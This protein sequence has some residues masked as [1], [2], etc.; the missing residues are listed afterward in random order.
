[1]VEIVKSAIFAKWLSGL[2]DKKAQRRI[3]KRLEHIENGNFGDCT[4]IGGGLS[5]VRIHYGP[6]Y[7]L[8][9]MRRGARIIVLLCGGDKGSQKRDIAKAKQLAEQWR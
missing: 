1:M 3:V 7:R 9:F 6:G 2:R 4:P 8:Y 5:E